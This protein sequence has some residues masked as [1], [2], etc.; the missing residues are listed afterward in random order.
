MSMQGFLASESS[1]YKNVLCKG[2]YQYYGRIWKHEAS[3]FVCFACLGH[4]MKE[5]TIQ[6][7]DSAL[8]FKSGPRVWVLNQGSLKS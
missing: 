8:S 4:S 1:V 5:L 3:M 2:E 7:G 6:L